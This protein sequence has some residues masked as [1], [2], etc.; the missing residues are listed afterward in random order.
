MRIKVKATYLDVPERREEHVLHHAVA[1][2]RDDE[3]EAERRVE[4]RGLDEHRGDR[5]VHLRVLL[6]ERHAC[7]HA[8]VEQAADDQEGHDDVERDRDRPVRDTEADRD[9]RPETR[10]RLRELEQEQDGDG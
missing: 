6:R 2:V 4:H 5:G 10:A 8:Q 3:Y 7:P 1:R 9:A